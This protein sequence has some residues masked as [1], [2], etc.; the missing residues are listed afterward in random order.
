MAIARQVAAAQ[1]AV[2]RRFIPASAPRFWA[3]ILSSS[4]CAT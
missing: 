3:T 2:A 4:I 1:N